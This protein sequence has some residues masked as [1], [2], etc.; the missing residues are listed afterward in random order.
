MTTDLPASQR[1]QQLAKLLADLTD[2]VLRGEQV[3][4][5]EQC[6]QHPAVAEELRRLWGAVMVAEAAGSTTNQEGTLNDTFAAFSLPTQFGDYTLE[7]ELGRGGMGVVYKAEQTSLK[8][9]VAVKMILRGELATAE[10]RRRFQTEAEAAGQLHHPNIVPVYDVG[11]QSGR[12][13]FTM[14]YIDGK[15]LQEI[16]LDGPMPPRDAAR[17]L[18]SVSRAIDYAHH[19]GVLHRDLKPSNILVDTRGNPRLTDFGLAKQ[20]KDGSLT[21]TG[22]VVGTP[23]YMSPELASGGRAEIGPASDV[24]SLGAILYHMLCGQPPFAA[25]TPVKMMMQVLEQDPPPPRDIVPDVDRDLEMIAIRCLQKP[26]DLRYESA[27][28]LASDLEAYLNDEPISA[29]SGR[30][31]QIIARLFRETHHAAVLENW[32][33]LWMWH[34]LVI[35]LTCLATQVMFWGGVTN[36]W[37]Y[38]GLWTVVFGTWAGVFWALR[39][40]MGP[41]TFVERQIAHVWAASLIGIAALFPFEAYLDLEVLALSPLLALVSGMVF[42]VKA[43]ILSGRF[44][45][46]AALLFATAVVMAITPNY[47]HLVFG[48]VSAACFFVPGLRYYSRIRRGP[49]IST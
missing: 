27:A 6:A 41:V 11:E 30:F 43:G 36:R 18:A 34:S 1:E 42:L 35:L 19:H 40:R 14:E 22:A 31:T 5:D 29:R 46:Q 13:Y 47:G 4:I 23:A 49:A 32:G 2:R 48:I 25:D 7:S 38:F 28:D 16:L 12:A 8:R 45:M 24:Y 26:A 21:R 20:V 44:Y 10:D 37:Y 15:T 33:L 9:P 17:V 39:R 3:N